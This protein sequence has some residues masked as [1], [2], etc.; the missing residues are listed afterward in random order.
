MLIQTLRQMR[1]EWQKVARK[2]AS[3]ILI[4]AFLVGCSGSKSL[5]L[6]VRDAGTRAGDAT[7]PLDLAGSSVGGDPAGDAALIRVEAGSDPS[8]P[9]KTDAGTDAMVFPHDGSVDAPVAPDQ[10]SAD[11]GG[12]GGGPDIPPGVQDAGVGGTLAE[13]GSRIDVASHV[14]GGPPP[15]CAVS[16]GMG[17][18]LPLTS[19][20]ASSASIVA[21][22][23]NGDGK[24]DLVTA[25]PSD[26]SVTVLL[27]KGDGT[28]TNRA[29]YGTGAVPVWVAAGDVNGDGKMDIVTANRASNTVSVLLGT[30]D[31]T[32]AFAQDSPCGA[33][34]NAVA[35]ADFD[36]DGHP[37]L[38][39]ANYNWDT[40]SVLL[41]KGDGTFTTKLDYVV[42]DGPRVVTTG[43]LNGDGKPDLMTVNGRAGSVSVLL[44]KGDGTFA[45]QPQDVLI[46]TAPIVAASLGDVDR[47]GK[48]DLVVALGGSNAQGALLVLLAKGDGTFAAPVGYTGQSYQTWL[49]LADANRDGNLD[50]VVAGADGLSVLVGQGDGAF[51][52]KVDGPASPNV[53]GLTLGDFNGDGNPDLAVAMSADGSSGSVGVLAGTKSGSFGADTTFPT[54]PNPNSVALAD[55]DRD[56][57]LDAVTVNASAGAGTVSVMLGRGDGTLAPRHDY[58]AGIAPSSL[59]LGDMDGDGQLDIAVADGSA[60]NVILSKGDGSFGTPVGYGTAGPTAGVALGDLDR[61]GKLDVVTVSPYGPSR[62]GTVSVLLGAD[63]GKLAPHV[64]Y[65][66]GNNPQA[67]ALGDVNADGKLDIVVANTGGDGGSSAGVLLGKGDGTV[68]SQVEYAAGCMPSAVALGDV[69]ADGKLDIVMA[70]SPSCSAAV[71]VFLGKGDG[72]FSKM[73][74]D[75]PPF[76][77]EGVATLVLRDVNGDGALDVITATSNQ[78]GTTVYFGKGD[79]TFPSSASYPVAASAVAVGDLTGDGRPDLVAATPSGVTVLRASCP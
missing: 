77:A 73:V 28:F 64:D 33:L 10:A 20:G 79:G 18:F 30:G 7:A 49:G 29:S 38:V 75:H 61:D 60:V 22:D 14:D 11:V 26:D 1:S 62:G 50:I 4:V 55:L 56:G 59:V 48:P 66:A 63:N 15:T 21:G 35:I 25:S 3:G 54:A 37:D 42:G 16:F 71:S 9:V 72:T 58:A 70:S 39:T 69:N 32:F 78:N 34:P 51:A 12:Q 8:S 53:A 45:S 44:G 27:G 57:N 40:V 17:N 5:S 67:V 76:S 36:G 41:G 47:D 13:D 19:T 31:G 46:E 23:L 74:E 68:A 52:P 43:D 65:P 6:G 2:R 24:L